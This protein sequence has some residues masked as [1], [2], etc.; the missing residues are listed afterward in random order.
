MSSK[1]KGNLYIFIT[2]FLWSL[3]GLILKY[4]PYGAMTTNGLRSII[5]LAVLLLYRRDLHLKVNRIIVIAAICMSAT[6]ILYVMANQL[7]TAANAIVIQYTAPIWVLIWNSA[8]HKKMPAKIDLFTMFLAFFGTFL[9]FFDGLSKGFLFGNFIALLSGISFS[10]VLFLNYLPDSSSEDSS[11][12]GFLLSFLIAIP[13]LSDVP[14]KSNPTAVI[15]ILILGIFQVGFAYI[16][17]AKGS[18]LT[19]PVTGSLIS[20]LEAMMNPLWVFLFYGEKIGRF[21]FFGA[22]FIILAVA[23]QILSGKEDA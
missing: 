23:L 14:A 7:T 16:F 6:N 20:L 4:I 18:R 10:G 22:V 8:Y 2:A 1:Q 15:A 19:T 3:G 13:F 5:A 17:F 9:F 21:A 12:I 11:I